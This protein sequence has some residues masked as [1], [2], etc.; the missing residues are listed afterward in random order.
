MTDNDKEN[1]KESLESKFSLASGETYIIFNNLKG[2]VVVWINCDK[3]MAIKLSKK[4]LIEVAPTIFPQIDLS[5][6]LYL[7]SRGDYVFTDKL[8]LRTLKPNAKTGFEVL[9][10]LKSVESNMKVNKS[11][12]FTPFGIS[13]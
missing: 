10:T 4:D 11:K 1:N 3:E 9:P 7:I 2:Q 8:V 13:F 12:Q 5:K 6:L